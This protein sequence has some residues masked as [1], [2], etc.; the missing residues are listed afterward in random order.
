MS[1]YLHRQVTK[2][3]MDVAVSALSLLAL[4]PLLAIV[5]LL[6]LW[7]MG[8]PAIFRQRRPGRGGR[9]FTV[10][11][12]RTMTDARGPDGRLLPDARRFTGLGRF[13][14]A[15]SIDEL[16]QL[17]NV[18]RGD[19]S[20]VGPRPLLME[21][22]E[23]YTPEQARRHE[24]RPGITGLAQVTGRNAMPF[25]KRLELDVYY[26]DHGS[27]AMDL[28]ILVLTVLRVVG[29]RLDDGAGQ[30]VTLVDDLGLHPDTRA[31]HAAAAN[32]QEV[33]P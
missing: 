25:S 18:L 15:S 3:G 21:Y 29:R 30:D 10:Y 2:R 22:L 31:L 8:R 5:W 4:S 20:L 19:L 24:V 7:R 11:K 6:V 27:L 23:R 9:P 17:W 16:P 12:F 14:R 26:V 28:K 1:P 33:P 13:L 32:S